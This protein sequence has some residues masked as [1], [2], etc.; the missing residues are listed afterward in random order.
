MSELLDMWEYWRDK[1]DYVYALEN[2]YPQLLQDNKD[3]QLAVSNINN[4]ERTIDKIFE[5]LRGEM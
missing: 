5:E 3:L 1:K 4:A 2:Y